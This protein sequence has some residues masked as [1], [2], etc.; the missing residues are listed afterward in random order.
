MPEHPGKINFESKL[1]YYVQLINL[2]KEQIDGNFWKAGDKIPGEPELCKL[3][4]VSRTVVRQALSELERDGLVVRRKGKGTFVAVPK[5]SESLAEKLTG[6]YQD[7]V[8]RKIQ[9]VT[10]VLRNKVVEANEK[11]AAQLEIAPGTSVVYIKRLRSVNDVPVQVVTSYLPYALCQRV[12]EADLATGSLYNFLEKE[13]GLYIAR[14]RRCIEAV[15][16]S[17]GDAKLLQV[18]R[19]APLVQ[20]ESISYLENGIPIEYYQA[21]HRGDRA[22]FEIELV[23]VRGPQEQRDSLNED[24]PG[25]SVIFSGLNDVQN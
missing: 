7:M 20:L 23:R 11:V 6:F 8:S 3:Y 1:P 24:L 12:T 5:I 9:P 22:R 17:E 14:A 21:L 4:C 18:E 16:A 10:Q 19:G 25:S 13:Y 2:L 15:A